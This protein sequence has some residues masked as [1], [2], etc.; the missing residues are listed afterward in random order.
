MS[1][2][3]KR[4][5]DAA[6]SPS[7]PD[8]ARWVKEQTLAIEAEH[9]ERVGGTLRDAEAANARNLE[10]LE[11]RRR[12]RAAQPRRVGAPQRQT[13]DQRQ[14]ERGVTVKPAPLLLA[15]KS[16][17][18]YC[19]RCLRC[20]RER[21]CAEIMRRAR[22]GEHSLRRFAW[23]LSSIALSAQLRK[24]VFADLGPSDRARAFTAFVDKVLDTSVPLMGAWR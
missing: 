6:S 9:A 10:R 7:H 1:I 16:P 4:P 23:R 3:A 2:E 14:K 5:T 22:L 15:P 20:K 24:G 17:C 19:G 12:M 13:R 11:Q 21:R 18:S 8:H